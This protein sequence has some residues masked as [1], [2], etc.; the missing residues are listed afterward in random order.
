MSAECAERSR[1]DECN[2]ATRSI[3]GARESPCPATRGRRFPALLQSQPG[4][5]S[6]C[7][8]RRALVDTHFRPVYQLVSPPPGDRFIWLV[9]GAAPSLAVYHSEL[10]ECHPVK[11]YGPGFS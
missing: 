3:I 6:R 7:G 10:C 9:D 8:G 2:R 4:Y 5:Y 1:D 11:R